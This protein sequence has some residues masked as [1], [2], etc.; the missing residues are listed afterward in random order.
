LE[1]I[2]CREKAHQ[3]ESG[4]TTKNG[5]GSGKWQ[6]TQQSRFKQLSSREPEKG[7]GR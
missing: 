2:L 5:Y 6:D 1:V 7:S 3:E 4:T